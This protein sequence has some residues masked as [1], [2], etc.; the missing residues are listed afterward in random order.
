MKKAAKK[1]GI[2]VLLCVFL[3]GIGCS[4]RTLFFAESGR[5]GAYVFVRA[6]MTPGYPAPNND[7]GLVKDWR[8]KKV[9]INL[10]EGSYNKTKSTSDTKEIK[11]QKVNN[12]SET[13]YGT[14]K[15]TYY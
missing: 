1:I 13:A 7:Y 15:W 4:A 12:P 10:R 11:L 5:S 3:M 9:T 8:V 6:Y 2:F 14:W